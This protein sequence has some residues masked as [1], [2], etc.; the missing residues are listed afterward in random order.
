MSFGTYG[1]WLFLIGLGAVPALPIWMLT[2]GYGA[3]SFAAV[4][5]GL[6]LMG[7]GWLLMQLD[8]R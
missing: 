3:R 7:L 2:D 5:P 1:A 8:E 6:L 4:L